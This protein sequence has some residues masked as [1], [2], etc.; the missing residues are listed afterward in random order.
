MAAHVLP[1]LPSRRAVSD[2]CLQN[3]LVSPHTSFP[4][5]RSY[6]V[7]H[8]PQNLL[9]TGS[10]PSTAR[11]SAALHHLHKRWSKARGSC[12]ARERTRTLRRRRGRG[13]EC[14][15]FLLPKV[16]SIRVSRAALESNE[17]TRQPGERDPQ[18]LS[19]SRSP[20]KTCFF[21]VRCQLRWGREQTGN[22]VPWSE[23]VTGMNGA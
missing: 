1:V 17:R 4:V 15:G 6:K 21:P 12:P 22:A 19:L 2:F 11:G 13:E 5:Y 10:C 20:P 8:L 7:L 3:V 9:V 23:A 18:Q 14:G 16:K